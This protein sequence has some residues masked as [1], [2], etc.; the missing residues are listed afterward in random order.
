MNK[1]E[2]LTVTITSDR[3]GE[4]HVHSS[5]EEDI[6]FD[7]G[8][9]T[10]EAHLQDAR[11]D[12]GRGALSRHPDR[13]ARGADDVIVVPMHGLGG[14]KDLPIPP[15]SRSRGAVAALVDLL[16]RAVAGLAHAAVRRPHARAARSRRVAAVRRRRRASRWTLRI[17]GL[18]VVRLPRLGADR[19]TRPGHQPGPRHVLRAGLGRHRAVLAAVRPGLPG[20]QP[21][22]HAQPAA[23][24][25]D[26]RRPGDAG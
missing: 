26:R 18:A 12:R 8:T 14:A 24:Q 19:G 2:P 1:D 15:R 22:A 4:L 5:P 13:P 25:G 21:G 10:Q 6:A 20:G 11:R 9:T 23:G 7:K 17:L 16:L 3:S